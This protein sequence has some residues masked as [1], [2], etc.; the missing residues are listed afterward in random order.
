MTAVLALRPRG[1]ALMLGAG[2][3]T[4]GV[5]DCASPQVRTPER[6]PP[7]ASVPIPARCESG[8]WFW[9]ADAKKLLGVCANVLEIRDGSTGL[10]LAQRSR[11]QRVAEGAVSRDGAFVAVTGERGIEIRSGRDL[12]LQS[13]LPDLVGGALPALAFS[14]D[15]SRLGAF[16]HSRQVLEL[17]LADAK[18]L[19]H[20]D[21]LMHGKEQPFALRYVGDDL[22]LQFGER[23]HLV[24]SKGAV[25]YPRW[26]RQSYPLDVSAD[27]AKV[28]IYQLQSTTIWDVASDRPIALLD[29]QATGFRGAFGDYLR[30]RERDH[31]LQLVSLTRPTQ[32]LTV[33][34]FYGDELAVSADQHLRAVVYGELTDWALSN[35][36]PRRLAW[37]LR[38]QTELLPDGTILEIATNSLVLRRPSD[39]TE[40]ARMRLAG[41]IL[42]L[43][44]SWQSARG[45]IVNLDSSKEGS[46]VLRITGN[47]AERSRTLPRSQW[48]VV[49]DPQRPRLALVGGGAIHIFDS[50][51][52]RHLQSFQAPEHWREIQFSSARDELVIFASGRLSFVDLK[53]GQVADS[54]AFEQGGDKLTVAP[55][56][57]YLTMR[58]SDGT[59][60]WSKAGIMS[61]PHAGGYGA[62]FSAD[63]RTLRLLS[64][65]GAKTKLETFESASGRKLSETPLSYLA[66][67]T[68]IGDWIAVKD[69]DVTVG[70]RIGAPGWHSLAAPV[71]ANLALLGFRAGQLFAL[72]SQGV[73][74]KWRLGALRTAEPERV[75]PGDNAVLSPDGELLSILDNQITVAVSSGEKM[76]NDV[77]S[78]WSP[79][80]RASLRNGA[81][82]ATD[83]AT[84]SVLIPGSA[85]A[86]AGNAQSVLAADNADIQLVDTKNPKSPRT[87]ALAS[88]LA[89]QSAD[90]LTIA[91]S[92]DYGRR[93]TVLRAPSWQPLGVVPCRYGAQRV[94]LNQDGSRLAILDENN[95]LQVRAVT[96]GGV[97]EVLGVFAQPPAPSTSRLLF[98]PTGR[99]LLLEG[100]PLRILRLRDG[101]VL[102]LYVGHLDHVDRLEAPL[103]FVDTHGDMVGDP[104]L[105]RE[106]YC[107]SAADPEPPAL[108]AEPCLLPRHAP[109]LVASFFAAN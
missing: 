39:R 50:E 48:H 101:E 97:G 47:G 29:V 42:S 89:A 104:D 94:A 77:A 38:P 65:D 3:C 57:Q 79:D 49:L 7:A 78:A 9:S 81:V 102:N 24:I 17:S 68:L 10:V 2:L 109:G 67:P 96:D 1:L 84:A 23:K 82:V 56:G 80:G 12:S 22:D 46:T 40:I 32:K 33:P 41:G 91:V 11:S 106:L 53:T 27:A 14:P 99:Y 61:F 5:A 28:A 20:F 55:N 43:E 98:D 63:S 8:P 87:L 15:G 83:G 73:L 16:L 108:R 105:A 6:A 90:Q 26:A 21:G 75:W 4:V 107:E 72:D 69:H 59:V 70:R 30:S 74:V 62:S 93:I 35:P 103:L 88:N 71:P 34:E 44:N 66:K 58:S 60:L 52:L 19:W 100:T 85:L 92:A 36:V 95:Q 51:S 54:V 13:V 64:Q 45:E 18:V 76:Y 31:G 86:F 25:R 37:H